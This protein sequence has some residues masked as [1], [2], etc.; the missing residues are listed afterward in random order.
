M[1]TMF[2]E[3]SRLLLGNWE[4]Y[5]D[6]QRAEKKLR[7]ELQKAIMSVDLRLRKADFWRP[8]W[9][10]QPYGFAQ[11]YIWHDNWVADAQ[12]LVWIGV[13][14]ASLEGI[15]SDGVPAS[16]YV[17]VPREQASPLIQSLRKMFAE[18]GTEGFGEVE[19]G[20]GG[21]IVRQV[22]PKCLPE[23]AD[24][25]ESSFLEPVIAFLSHY[26]Q[27]EPEITN[28]VKEYLKKGSPA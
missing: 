3:E 28:T 1:A 16:G 17:W 25:F 4:A 5:Q 27:Y 22:L 11:V 6:V 8:A 2:S 20:K 9:H 24:N 15:F 7:A 14:G 26:A 21:Y 18:K 23:D 19:S 13:E 12:K 10:C